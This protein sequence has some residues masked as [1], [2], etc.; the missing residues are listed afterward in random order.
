VIDKPARVCDRPRKAL[1][2]GFLDQHRHTGT[3]IFKRQRDDYR[4]LSV[5]AKDTG[6]RPVC[7]MTKR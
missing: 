5:N 4:A 7:S 6:L 1:N 2:Y 3:L